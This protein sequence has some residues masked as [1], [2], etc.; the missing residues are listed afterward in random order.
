LQSTRWR[1]TSAR[2]LQRGTEL[3]NETNQEKIGK[4]AVAKR[5]CNPILEPS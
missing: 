2:H 3:K 5:S 4:Q 1:R